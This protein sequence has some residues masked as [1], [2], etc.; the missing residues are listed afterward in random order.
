[1]PFTAKI[2]LEN[3]Q[4]SSEGTID[5]R[6]LDLIPIGLTQQ[7]KTDNILFIAVESEWLNV[8][9]L[10]TNIQSIGKEEQTKILKEG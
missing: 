4:S 6:S 9:V 3:D 7:Y 10:R 8:E 5:P 1:M 2:R